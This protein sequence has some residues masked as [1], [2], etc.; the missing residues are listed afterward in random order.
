MKYEEINAAFDIS[1]YTGCPDKN[2]ICIF[3]LRNIKINCFLGH[4]IKWYL[5]Y[6]LFENSAQF[7]LVWLTLYFFII[8]VIIISVVIIIVS[9]K[10]NKRIRDVDNKSLKVKS[11]LDSIKIPALMFQRYVCDTNLRSNIQ[12]I[13]DSIRRIA[14]L[15][16][17]KFQGKT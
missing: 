5:R 13:I 17:Q 15:L 12:N 4:F 9:D 3:Y 14:D 6:G 1:K 8:I 10:I 11:D 16:R 7:S 2:Q